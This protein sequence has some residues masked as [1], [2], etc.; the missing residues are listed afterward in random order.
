MLRR[1]EEG[2]GWR[3]YFRLLAH[4]NASRSPILLLI[5]DQFLPVVKDYTTEIQAVFPGLGER[6][7]LNAYGFML[8]AAMAVFSDNLRLNFY[9]GGALNTAEFEKQYANM[10]VFV[11]GGMLAMGNELSQ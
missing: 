4:L 3:A 5:A 9:S 6:A 11:V 7:V 10:R 1:C 8:A 2:E